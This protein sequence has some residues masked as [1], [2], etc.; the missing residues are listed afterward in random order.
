M[1]KI[2][3]LVLVFIIPAL[4]LFTSFRINAFDYDFYEK[5]F[6]KHG[7]YGIAEKDFVDTNAKE[8]ISYFNNKAKV[9]EIFNEKEEL[10]LNDVKNI[11]QKTFLI[12]Y[13]LITLFILLVIYFIYKREFRL[14]SLSLIFGGISTLIILLLVSNLDFESTFTGF[15]EVAFNNTNWILN[16]ET[17]KLIVIFPLGFF[18][19][20]TYEIVRDS[21]Y[22]AAGVIAVGLLGIL[23]LRLKLNS[24]KRV[25]G[26]MIKHNVH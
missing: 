9:P 14:L 18:Q 7:I 4:I 5:Q 11:L 17:D 20:M 24:T 12:H 23:I 1:R 21:L 19:D 16:P 26:K 6:E 2:L 22:F 8:L 10:H 15:H 25:E 3:A 13:V